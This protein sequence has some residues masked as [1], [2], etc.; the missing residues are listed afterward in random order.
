MSDFVIPEFLE[1]SGTDEIHARILSNISDRI[2]KTKGGIVWDMT[3]PPALEISETVEF[4]IVEAIKSMFPMWAEGHMLDYHGSNR[5]IVRRDAAKA[6]GEVR[7]TGTIGHLIPAG[8]L[9]STT[10]ENDDE[11]IMFITLDDGKLADVNGTGVADVAVEAVDAGASGNVAAGCINRLDVTDSEVLSV[12]NTVSTTG[13]IDI[14]DDE[15]YRERLIE[16]DETQGETF[17]GSYADYKRW[18]LSVSGV[19][20]ASVLQA[21]DDS[22]L[23]KI[24][25]TDMDGNPATDE[26]CEDV[27]NY[28]MSPGNPSERLAPINAV[29]EVSSS[30]A[31]TV[32]ISATIETDGVRDI[33]S[34]KSDFLNVLKEYY[35]TAI[36]EKEIKYSKIGALLIDVDGVSDYSNLLLNDGTSNIVVGTEYLPYS[37]EK[38][39][40]FT[41]VD[42]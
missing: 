34:I 12:S 13:G 7:F 23:V 41:Q 32:T 20:G 30:V 1:N 8:T 4:V 39:V 14:E 10:S 40:V 37:D 35:T 29:I 31:M 36:E 5:G 6:R 19:G 24:I 18:A 28:I 21:T 3:Y 42:G 38:S 33:A 11:T 27:Y 15:S 17:I 9:L 26:L 2:D 16:Y 22:G 25:I